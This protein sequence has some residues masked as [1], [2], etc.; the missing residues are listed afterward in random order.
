MLFS[1]DDS[2]YNVITGIMTNIPLEISKRGVQFDSSC[3][4][5]VKRFP[6]EH[7]TIEQRA[8]LPASRHDELTERIS[9][10]SRK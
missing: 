6:S 8:S 5:Y 1:T 7:S 2:T 9:L 10:K 3:F 4:V